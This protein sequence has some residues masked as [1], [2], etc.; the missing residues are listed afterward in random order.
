MLDKLAQFEEFNKTILPQLRA[1][2][3]EGAKS[4]DIL[5]FSRAHAAARIVS[6]AATEA[7]STKALAASRDILDR[8]MGKAVERHEQTHKFAKLDDNALDA[9]VISKLKEAELPQ[10]AASS[11]DDEEDDGL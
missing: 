11:Q 6:I 8:T 7:D 4:E 9:L 3:K 1:M 10:L 2:L 5:E